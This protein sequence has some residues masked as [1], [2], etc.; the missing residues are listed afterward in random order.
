[1][2]V[3]LI[4]THAHLDMS[5]FDK[6]RTETIARALDSGVGIITVGTD[7]ESSRKAI[8]ISERYPGIYAAAG[9]HPHDVTK[10]GKEDII[11]LGE[12]AKHP[13]VVAIGETGLDFYRDYSPGKKQ[14][15]VLKWQL[16]L[17]LKSE[18]PIIIHCRKAEEALLKLLRSFMSEHSDTDK[19][20]RGV[21]HC[22]SSD[23]D[24]AKELLDTGFYLSF[25]AYVGYPGSA[26]LHTVI[27]NVPEGRLLVETD[28]P[29]LPPQSYRGKRN[30]PSYLPLTVKVLASIRGEP[31][32]DIADATTQNAQ[33]LFRLI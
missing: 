21:I 15:E 33:R 2:K 29:F 5:A 20:L 7:L 18:L 12:I 11:E 17:S 16:E 4:D 31:Y 1:M 27:K 22:F 6:D 14:I 9:I 10:I 19:H 24:T 8:E 26:S 28:C 23:S 30:E 25:G 13:R 32:Q 3:S